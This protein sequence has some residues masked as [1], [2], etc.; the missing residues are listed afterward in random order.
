[1]T[2]GGGV[3]I[4]TGAISKG[5]CGEQTEEKRKWVVLAR[6]T[7][8]IASRSEL[9]SLHC[10]RHPLFHAQLPAWGVSQ[11]IMRQETSTYVEEPLRT[12]GLQ[13]A[14]HQYSLRDMC[15]ST[16]TPTLP[17]LHTP[18][19]QFTNLQHGVSV[20]A[21]L[22]AS[23]VRETLKTW[24]GSGTRRVCGHWGPEKMGIRS[25]PRW[26]PVVPTVGGCF[27]QPTTPPPPN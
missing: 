3:R 7:E 1:M 11:V 6:H 8:V 16:R 4:G 17:T 26:P 19:L 21:R 22:P 23:R 27:Y 9:L 5:A 20:R 2:K 12:V 24:P 10:P 18:E 14:A 13:E 25:H 15:G